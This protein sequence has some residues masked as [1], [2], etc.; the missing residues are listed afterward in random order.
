VAILKFEIDDES[1]ELDDSRIMV[2]EVAAIQ[3]FTTLKSVPE[4]MAALRENSAEA[5]QAAGWLAM[6]RAGKNRKLSEVD[7]DLVRWYDL[8]QDD[9]ETED[10]DGEADPTE[11]EP[12]TSSGSE[13]STGA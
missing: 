8:N 7:F 12:E 11:P 9:D 5:I 1:F 4:F 13:T 10:E 6:K 3:R 2:A